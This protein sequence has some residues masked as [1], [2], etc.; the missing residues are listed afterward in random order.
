MDEI[1]KTF[2]VLPW[3]HMAVTTTGIMRVCC[4]ST[5]GVNHINK[6][7]GKPYRI[8]R[9][10]VEEAWN[11]ESYRSIRRQFLAG[12]RPAICQPC[13]REEDSGIRSPRIGWNQRWGEDR[14]YT[15]D[16]PFAIRYVDLRLGN[17]CNLKC[18][19]CNP[20]SSSMWL[21][22]WS[23]GEKS[24]GLYGGESELSEEEYASLQAMDWYTKPETWENIYRLADSLDEIYL[25]GGEPTLI[26]Q[27]HLL[28]DYLIE[29]DKAK[30]I[31][32]K[33][34]TNLTNV[35]RNLLDKWTRFRE[36]RLNCSIDATG[37]LNRY[38]RFPSDWAKIEENFKTV[39]SLP[40]S[41]IQLHCTVQMYNIL[42]L[43][44][45]IE[46]ASPYGHDIYFNVLDHP[47]EMNI[48][49]L[50]AQ[51]KELAR[52]RLE[53]YMH[54]AKMPGIVSYMLGED[55]SNRY[56][57]FVAYTR[58]IDAARGEDLL[59]VVPEFAQTDGWRS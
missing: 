54:L 22:D 31:K 46:W 4:N 15:E 6:P 51:L 48:R 37:A 33:Y 3:M 21:K 59:Q 32:L 28:L 58:K 20:H 27:Q 41:S 56:A 42:R 10:S 53:P 43:H 50:P 12:E 14:E 29:N 49:V 7:D 39:R 40:N 16:A 18:R 25:T 9:D 13:F 23:D 30:N 47:P 57:A 26:E 44:E 17:L 36:V 52:A 1:S 8:N 19:M 34:N 11:S 45:F 55:W 2:C 5:P 24:L 38:I 35:P